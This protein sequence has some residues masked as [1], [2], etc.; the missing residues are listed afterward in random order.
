MFQDQS[1]RDVRNGR[2]EN[3][4]AQY[5]FRVRCLL[6][7]SGSVLVRRDFSDVTAALLLKHIKCN[8]KS[9]S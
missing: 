8:I 2:Y 6:V 9:F 5:R 4:S 1:S 3:E 7:P